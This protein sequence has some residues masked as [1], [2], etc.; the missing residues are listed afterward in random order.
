MNIAWL[1][2][3]VDDFRE[4]PKPMGTGEAICLALV[5]VA[6]GAAV[7][8]ISLATVPFN[9]SGKLAKKFRRQKK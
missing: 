4:T 8:L 5:L 6:F 1:C 7:G 9:L 2:G 3:N